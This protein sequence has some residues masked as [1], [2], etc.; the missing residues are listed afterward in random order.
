MIMGLSLLV[1]L[2][3]HHLFALT[4]AMLTASLSISLL[5]AAQAAV[6]RKYNGPKARLLIALMC[7]NSTAGTQL[8]S[9]LV[10][11]LPAAPAP[12]GIGHDDAAL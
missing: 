12:S 1:G 8:A 7:L 5:R 10:A 9:V 11:Y 3:Y 2:S 6:P 4:G